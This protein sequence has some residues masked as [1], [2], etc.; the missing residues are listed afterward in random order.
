MRTLSP[1]PMTTTAL[2]V[3]LVNVTRVFGGAPALV[4][5]DLAIAPGEAI[6][7]R[8]PNGAGKTT[9]LRVIATAISPTYGGGSVLG[10][11][12]LREREQIRRRVELLTHATRLYDDLTAVENLRFA[13]TILGADARLAEPALERVGLSEVGGE[14]VRSFSHGMRQRVAI[15]RTF[16]RSPDLVMLDEP[17]TGLDADARGAVDALV[18]DARS[19][20]RTAIVATHHPLGHG[21]VDREIAME[22]GRVLLEGVS[23]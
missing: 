19:I 21:L 1:K 18:A 7:L 14:R 16:L 9:L 11:D 17:Y 22:G 5:V 10:H 13:A 3:D 4:R 6:W 2:A 15:A 8:G 20:G 12:L 23:A